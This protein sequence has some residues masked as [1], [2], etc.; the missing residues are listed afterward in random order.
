M[1]LI[2]DIA[3]A[4]VAA[5]NAAP[6]GTFAQSFTAQR[7]YLP[8]FD[9]KEM[10]DLH[11]T[12]VPKGTE[13]QPGTRNTGRYDCSIDVGVQK[14][15]ANAQDLSEVDSLLTLAEGIAEYF[16]NKVLSPVQAAWVRSEHTHLYAQ[17]H[18]RELGQFT[19]VV[20]LTFRVLR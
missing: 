20:T 15:L 1:S 9:L 11:V 14:K 16:R 18:L 6:E 4:V 3:D 7:M 19:S 2:I 8:Q 10:S 17:D 13:I 5:L 12:V